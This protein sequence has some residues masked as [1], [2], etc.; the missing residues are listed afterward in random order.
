VAEGLGKINECFKKLQ[1][2]KKEI[3]KLI[4]AQNNSKD[5]GKNT[6]KEVTKFEVQMEAIKEKKCILINNI[7]RRSN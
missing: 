4:V 6:K 2:N 7:S 1:Q 3:D 5:V